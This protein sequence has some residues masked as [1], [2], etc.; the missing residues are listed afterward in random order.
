MFTG[1][2]RMCFCNLGCCVFSFNMTE[3]FIK[4][5]TFNTNEMQNKIETLFSTSYELAGGSYTNNSKL[6]E[7]TAF[8]SVTGSG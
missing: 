4:E 5:V 3:I 7:E 1:V 2:L 8:C 6:G